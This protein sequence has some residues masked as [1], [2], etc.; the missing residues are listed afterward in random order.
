MKIGNVT[1]EGKIIVGP[2]AGISN[3]AFRR[4]C[5]K[6]NPALIYAEM[7][8]DK[9]LIYENKRTIDMLDCLDEEH[10][11]TMQVFGSTV[12]EITKAAIYIDKYSKA[13]IIDINMGCPVNKVAKKANSGA[14]LLKD[15]ELVYNIV[16]SVKENVKKPVT[17]KIRLGWDHLSINYLEIG[18]LIEKAGADAICLHARTRSDFYQGKADWEAIKKLKETVNIPVIGNGDINSRED[19]KKMLETTNCDAVMI[20]RGV[21][22]N[23]WLI[24]ECNNYLNNVSSIKRIINNEEKAEIIIKHLNYLIELKGEKKGILEFRTH[25]AYYVRG[26]FNATKFK[27]E[28]FKISD[29]AIL[30]KMIYEFL[31]LK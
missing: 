2:M 20:S 7:V 13:D 4:I 12:N 30:E 8:S 18:K 10:P 23:P 6:F 3:L 1:I 5:K 27:Q 16:K 14:S 21:L 26:M 15:P 29:K 31:N 28:I 22:G 24:E 25:L 11:I 9:A 19:A 17:V